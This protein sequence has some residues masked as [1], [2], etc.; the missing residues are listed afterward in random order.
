MAEAVGC[1][2]PVGTPPPQ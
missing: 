2:E 1:D